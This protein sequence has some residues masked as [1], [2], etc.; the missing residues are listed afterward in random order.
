MNATFGFMA[1]GGLG[2][3]I[4]VGDL[5]GKLFTKGKAQPVE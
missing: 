4:E 5:L 1:G 3:G 2:F